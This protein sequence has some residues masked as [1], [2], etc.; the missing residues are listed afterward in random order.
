MSV[1]LHTKWFWVRVQLQPL[2]LQILRVLWARSS[3]IFR[4]LYSVDWLWK[5]YMTWQE[6]AV[7]EKNHDSNENFLKNHV[8]SSFYV[9]NCIALSQYMIFTTT[10]G[11]KFYFY[12]W[13][14][15]FSYFFSPDVFGLLS[16]LFCKI[17]FVR[18]IIFLTINSSNTFTG[19]KSETFDESVEIKNL[20]FKC[21]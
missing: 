13:I 1:H 2:K 19:K 9:G 17:I 14:F 12:G 3:L 4:Q 20:T 5:V 7:N 10:I 18:I 11:K 21:S 16:I 6:L 15:F 8:F